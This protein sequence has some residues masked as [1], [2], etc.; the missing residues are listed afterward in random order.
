MPRSL[1]RKT[2]PAILQYP[3][4]PTWDEMSEEQRQAM[5]RDLAERY[6][7]LLERAAAPAPQPE[8]R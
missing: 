6:Q 7:R 4:A 1:A 5:T 2:M 8:P 3:D